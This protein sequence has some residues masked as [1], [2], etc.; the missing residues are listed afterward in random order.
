MTRKT[1]LRCIT[2]GSAAFVI[3]CGL[4]WQGKVQ[5][6]A[7]RRLLTNEYQHSFIEL[8][9]QVEGLN[10]ALQKGRYVTSPPLQTALYAEV[11]SRAAAAQVAL[12]QLPFSNVE[13]E[14]TAAFL[15]KT[16]DYAYALARQAAAG[17]LGIPERETLKDLANASGELALRL[18]SLEEELNDRTFTLETVLDAEQ[19]LSAQ[20]QKTIP[21]G[22]AFETME[23]EF[24]ELPT[25]L[26]DG[27]F[28]EHLTGRT[29]KFLEGLPMMNEQAALEA[30]GR[31]LNFPPEAFTV[32]SVGN[33]ALPTYSLSLETSE[34]SVWLEVSQQGGIP[35][36]LLLS[37]PFD[38]PRISSEEALS[39]AKAFLSSHNFPNMKETYLIRQSGLLT[40]NFAPVQ[41]GV[42]CYPDLI[43]ITV[44][45]DQGEIAGFEASNY[46]TH[47]TTRTL[48]SPSISKESAQAT[49]VPELTVL[50]HQLALIPTAGE[51]EILCHEFKCENQDGGHVLV[52]INAQTGAEEKILLLLEDENGTLVL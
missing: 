12:G 6:A 27:P 50:S 22:S 45:L 10:S 40:I 32:A 30:G 5:A 13:L 38:L 25:L 37:R 42:L 29:P 17:G 23:K 35:V 1:K 28:S 33:G 9:D 41:D 15:S 4:A 52:Y 16:G 24:P 44:A 7:Y 19:R 49:L 14:E 18:D 8:T 21:A 39:L 20:N 3:L 11:Y 51:Q 47:H 46:L 43:K 31:F 36:T 34:E 26:Y 48:P 2:F